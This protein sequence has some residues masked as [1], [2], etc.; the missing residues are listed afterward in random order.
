MAVSP[1]RAVAFEILLRV[2]REDSYASELLHSSLSAKISS[3]DHGLATELVMGVLR[4]RSLL[5]ERLA[6]ASSQKLA[7]L[8]DEV[9]TA[10][11][12]G[13]YQFD[14][15]TRVPMRAAIFE[16]VELV[17]AA[18]KRSAAPF[19]NAVL[20]KLAAAG[21][22]DVLVEIGAPDAGTLARNA[23]HPTWLVERWTKQY[24]LE[25]ARQ[26][27]T[28]DQA[29]PD[30]AIRIHDNQ[31]EAEVTEAGVQLAPGRLLTSARRVIAGDVTQT[32]AYQEGRVS[33]QDEASQMVALLVGRGKRILDCCAAPG[34]KTSL[35][36]RNNPQAAVFATELHP[37]R[38]RLL[39]S[40]SRTPNVYVI[41]ADA[42]S[43]PF[44][45]PF[46]CI[47]ADVPCS[48]TGTLGRNPEI[49]WRLK[50]EDLRDLQARQIAILKSALTQLTK[51]GR[52]VYSTCSLEPEENEAVMA[53]ALEGASEFKI[54]DLKGQL[55]KMRQ[56]GE[57]C[58]TD[59]ASL[60]NGPYLRTIPGVHPC[61]GFF[62]AM[63]E[64]KQ[65]E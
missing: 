2:E 31:A 30:T 32:R 16:S 63:V 14:F 22:K 38:A 23:A 54:A 65:S 45:T 21:A 29:V 26:I 13:A 48:G 11:R 50:V 43:L 5:D 6:T 4:W 3:R 8:D 17:K 60:V 36:A 47:L 35:L 41:A 56:A 40:L 46:D 19:V 33:I 9:L 37:H 52:L 61:D 62:A 55:E 15:L 7:R 25:A 20:R 51:G 44:S 53:A 49:K 27:C 10:L 59:V 24:G 12:L 34:S 64:R 18:R 57:L 39:R 42:R 28:H 58:W 1:G